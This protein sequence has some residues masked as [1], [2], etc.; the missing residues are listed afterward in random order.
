MGSVSFFTDIII[1]AAFW[2]CGTLSL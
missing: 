2:P 1:P